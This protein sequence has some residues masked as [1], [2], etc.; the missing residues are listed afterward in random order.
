MFQS[1]FVFIEQMINYKLL[2]STILFLFATCHPSMQSKEIK[3]APLN[4]A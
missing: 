1:L 4:G 3:G 2:I